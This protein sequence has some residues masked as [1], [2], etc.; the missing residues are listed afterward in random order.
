MQRSPDEV[1][2]QIERGS[3]MQAVLDLPAFHEAVDFLTQY[4]TA[5]IVACRPGYAADAEALSHHHLMQHA[6]TEIVAQLQQWATVG[7]QAA[8]ALEWTREHGDND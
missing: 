2:A 1:I 8:R 6:L 7:E 5:A 4:H 3:A